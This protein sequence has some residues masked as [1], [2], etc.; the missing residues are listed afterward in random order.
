MN[1]RL[2]LA[3]LAG[4]IVSV[5]ACASGGGGA[6]PAPTA[7]AEGLEEGTPPSDN[8]HTRSAALYLVQAQRNPNLEEKRQ[9]YEEGLQA[10]LAGV[11]NDPGNPKGYFQ[12]AQAF[13]GLGD[14]VGADSMF[15]KAEEIYPRYR[16]ESEPIRE[17]Q[18]VQAYN[19]SI[20]PLQAGNLEDAAAGFERAHTIFRGRPEA[21][22]NLGSVYSRLGDVDKAADYYRQ[23]LALLQGPA[24][25]EQDEETQASWR[26]S[27]EIAAFNLAQLY[28]QADR[29][30]EAVDAYNAYLERNPGNITA[31]SNLAVVLS[32]ME[33]TDSAAAIYDALL[34][35]PDM[36]ARDYF[37]TGIGLFQAE[38]YEQA[39]V[40]FRR[41][42]ELVPTGR[43][44]LYNLAQALYLAEQY[45]ELLPAAQALA[46][47]DTHNKNA[48]LLLAQAQNRSGDD[49]AAVATMERRE[50]LPFEIVDTQLQPQASGGASLSGT[51]TNF[52][53]EPGTSVGLTFH[54]LDGDGQDVG[55]Q[56]VQVAAPAAEESVGFQVDFQSE[57]GII[58]YNYEVTAP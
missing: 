51:L 12:A 48:L 17:Q 32:K 33:M 1:F 6:P 37:V 11:E 49:Q 39:A 30:Q 21:M 55:T 54:F 9:R 42:T 13:L 10:A 44:G 4:L 8:V 27:E 25:D 19:Q 15:T 28:A 3:L 57:V 5:G 36:S 2:G 41:T 18:W 14:H 43:D 58:A 52:G 53:L 16:L 40:A 20:G 56:A 31:M 29:N 24:L 38:Q 45:E 7:G 46:E 22:L 34:S 26:E 35:R 47:V 50:A 23:A